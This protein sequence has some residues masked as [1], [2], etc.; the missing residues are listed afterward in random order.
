VSRTTPMSAGVCGRPW[1]QA[2]RRFCAFERPW[3]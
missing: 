1:Q 2:R 3:V